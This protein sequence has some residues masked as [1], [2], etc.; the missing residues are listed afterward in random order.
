MDYQEILDY[1]AKEEVFQKTPI[2][3]AF[4]RFKKALITACG[5]FS[6]SATLEEPK[7]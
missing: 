6:I 7:L 5:A 4:I 2:G 1:Q 3:A